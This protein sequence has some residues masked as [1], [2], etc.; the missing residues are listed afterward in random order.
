[1]VASEIPFADSAKTKVS[2]FGGALVDSSVD[3]A[4]FNCQV[5]MAGCVA[6]T[7]ALVPIASM[8]PA[9]MIDMIRCLFVVIR[10]LLFAARNAGGQFEG[11]NYSE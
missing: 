7:A 2:L 1:V 6:A 5:P 4:R 10:V 11:L 8:A 9:A 3:L